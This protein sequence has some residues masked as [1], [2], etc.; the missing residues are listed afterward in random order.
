MP[1]QCVRCSSF[2]DDGSE[3]IIK[4]C[5][6][7]GKLFFF[8]KKDSLKKAEKEVSK[9]SKADKKQIEEDVFEMIKQILVLL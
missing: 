9:L 7:G 6:C 5:Q 2:F 1:H 3:E 8:I 4:G